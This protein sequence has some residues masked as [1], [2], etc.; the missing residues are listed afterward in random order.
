MPLPGKLGRAPRAGALTTTRPEIS[1]TLP[2]AAW[3][4]AEQA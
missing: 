2:F 4:L 1:G 3:L